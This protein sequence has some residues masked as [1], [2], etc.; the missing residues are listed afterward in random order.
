M[1][2]KQSIIVPFIKRKRSEGMDRAWCKWMEE[3]LYKMSI[4]KI[5][6]MIS[7]YAGSYIYMGER[8]GKV[9]R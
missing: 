1:R 6:Q 4:P 2:T 5:N 9:A 3:K 8:K 7:L